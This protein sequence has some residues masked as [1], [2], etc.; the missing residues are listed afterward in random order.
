V[1]GRHLEIEDSLKE[2]ARD[3]VQK[4]TKFYDRI[5]SIEVVYDHEAGKPSVEV[6]VNTEPKNTFVGHE[7]GEDM[8]AVTDTVVDKLER[9]LTRHKEKHRNRKHPQ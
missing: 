1:S 4:L 9:Q 8:F 3:K 6:I 7:M 2:Y 5:Q